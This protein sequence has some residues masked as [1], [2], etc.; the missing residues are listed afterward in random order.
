L[1]AYKRGG[2]VLNEH[3]SPIRAFTQKAIELIDDGKT[4][5][6][7]IAFIE[8]YYRLVL[9]TPEETKRLNRQNRSK[10]ADDRLEA[11]GVELADGS[12]SLGLTTSIAVKIEP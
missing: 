3:V 8:K 12:A 10:M 5:D 6:D 7:L 1:A 4:D 9:L 2:R 11:A